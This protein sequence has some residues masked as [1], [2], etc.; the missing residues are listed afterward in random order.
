[1]LV[2][3]IYKMS[4][5]TRCYVV[6][7]SHQDHQGSQREQLRTL[8]T[9]QGVACVSS[10]QR[11]NAV[12]LTDASQCF[13]I[14][15]VANFPTSFSFYSCVTMDGNPAFT[16]LST[17][18]AFRAAINFNSMLL[19]QQIWCSGNYWSLMVW[20]TSC[21]NRFDVVLKVIMRIFICG[22]FK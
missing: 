20:Q 11:Q 21:W 12:W 10:K 16:L 14:A 15:R 17:A 18:H 6:T 13:Q 7:K 5:A 2:I 9:F 22:M 4:N 1:M 19:R 3:T 8:V